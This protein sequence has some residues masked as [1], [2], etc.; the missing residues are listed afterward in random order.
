ML[1][2]IDTDQ[3]VDPQEAARILSISR[4]AIY[5]RIEAGTIGAIRIGGR[6]CIPR[7]EIERCLSKS[8]PTKQ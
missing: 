2:E 6:F 4:I 1:I 3:L 5:K 8:L 7:S